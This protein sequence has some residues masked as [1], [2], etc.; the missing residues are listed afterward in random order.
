MKKISLI[1]LVVVLLT[2][3]KTNAQQTTSIPLIHVNGI[4]EVRVQPDEV[5]INLGVE[6]RHLKLEEARTQT[7][8]QTAAIL[9]YLKKQG[10]DQKD[11]QTSYV[12]VQP[13]YSGGEYGRTTPESYMAQK[14]MVVV[15]KQL[16]NFEEIMSG[17][18]KAG[19]NHVDGINFRVSDVEK[20]KVEARKKAVANAKMKAESLTSELNA[21]LGRVYTINE[22]SYDNG[23]RPLYTETAMMK[24]AVRDAGSATIAGGEVVVT[25]NVDISF[26]IE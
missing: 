7:D 17:L 6:T 16:N 5:V 4:G 11:V 22:S 19:A 18:Y 20:Y 26:V 9:K 24:S 10:V 23:P 2:F 21:K 3:M 25:S 1:A 15:V 13:I 8:A 12:N 14:N